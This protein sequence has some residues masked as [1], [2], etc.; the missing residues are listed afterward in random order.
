MKKVL[1]LLLVFLL[2]C[3]ALALGE[4]EAEEVEL[5]DEEWAEMLTPD[6]D[7]VPLT[8][9]EL[10]N[11]LAEED[12][13]SFLVLP[14]DWDIDQENVF[15][16]LLVGSDSYDPDK[17]GRSDAVIVVQL[18]AD[19]KTIKM[20]SFLRDLYVPIP[21]KGNNRINASYIWGGEKLL[22][23]VLQNQFGIVT[24]AY[25]EVNFTRMVDVID[26]I[27]GIEL[28]LTEKEMKQVNSILRFYNTYIG[29][30]GGGPAAV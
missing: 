16:L 25:C 9:E 12:Q 4:E 11:A 1:S 14:E 24:D 3:P 27:G 8:E 17:R 22:R 23:R 30:S 21:G 5:T 15:T 29:D 13:D 19:T 26:R 7:L 6:D 10:L 20:A 18:N 28:S 2:L